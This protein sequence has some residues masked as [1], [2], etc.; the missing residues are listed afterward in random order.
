MSLRLT[1]IQQGWCLYE[2][3]KDDSQVRTDTPENTCADAGRI[4]SKATES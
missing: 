3:R 1:L 2:K 4:W